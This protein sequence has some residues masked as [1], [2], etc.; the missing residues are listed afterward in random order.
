MRIYKYTSIY[1]Y[2]Y[3]ILHIYTYIHIYVYTHIHIYIYTYIHIYIYT[4]IHIYTYI[5]I[6][7]Y[8]CIVLRFSRHSRT[9]LNGERLICPLLSP[10]EDVLEWRE[11]HLSSPLATRGWR[12]AHWS[13]LKSAIAKMLNFG[14]SRSSEWRE[15]RVVLPSPLA[16]QGRP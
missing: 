4:Y 13:S 7:I 9:S 2:I 5:R 6:Y 10:L 16:T 15:E 12:E 3:K 14:N 1:I 8:H 11:A